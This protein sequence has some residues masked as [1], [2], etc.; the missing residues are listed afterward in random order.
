MRTHTTGG[1]S[2]QSRDSRDVG[3]KFRV[4]WYPAPRDVET[5]PDLKGPVFLHNDSTIAW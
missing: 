5:F 1:M 3:L 4:P 2:I